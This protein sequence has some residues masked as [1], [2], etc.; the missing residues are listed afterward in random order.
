MSASWDDAAPRVKG[1]AMG[2]WHFDVAR[3]DGSGEPAIQP[4]QMLAQ[5]EGHAEQVDPEPHGPVE[6][7]HAAPFS[8]CCVQPSRSAKP[9]NSSASRRQSTSRS[10]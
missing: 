1:A 10:G 6:G 9:L 5:A 4:A 3:K 2:G 7:S 8:I